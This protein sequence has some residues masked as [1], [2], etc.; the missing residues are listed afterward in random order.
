MARVAVVTDSTADIPPEL[1]QRYGIHV[2]PLTVRLGGEVFEDRVTITPG[3]FMRRLQSCDEFPTT[4]QPSV[5]RFQQV[6]NALA[7][8]HD[9]IVSIH[10]SSR[11][12]GTYQ[13]ARLARDTINGRLPI[14]VIDSR[15]ASMGLG[16]A[17]LHAARLA[18]EGRSLDEV[19]QAAERALEATHVMFLLDTLEY[20]RRGGRIGRAAEI[21][22]S[23]LQLKPLLRLDEGIVVPFARTRTRPKATA[24]LI[25]LVHEFPRV[26]QL[27][28]V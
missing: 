13:S 18:R 8:E 6:Y 5:G 12:S 1:I 22:G 4:S 24:G 9:G 3:E 27:A 25:Q 21:V 26:E 28:I 2:V 11:L 14:A 16:F 17:V 19:K 7:E 10:L 20:L 23:I 15:S